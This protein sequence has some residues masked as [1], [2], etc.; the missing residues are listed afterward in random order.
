[1]ESQINKAQ[2]FRKKYGHSQTM[3][4]LMKKYKCKTV[5]EY[6]AIRKE[7]KKV[8]K[9]V[10]TVSQPKKVPVLSSQKKKK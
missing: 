2:L 9:A 6:R 1:M 8:L 5:D 4:K 3:D 10:K 7:N